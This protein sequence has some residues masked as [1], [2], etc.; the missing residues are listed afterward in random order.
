MLTIYS[1]NKAP[2]SRFGAKCPTSSHRCPELLPNFLVPIDGHVSIP[3]AAL[4]RGL[5]DLH[6]LFK[7]SLIF[8]LTTG[9]G[10]SIYIL[11]CKG[12]LGGFHIQTQE[13]SVFY[14]EGLTRPQ[15][16]PAQIGLEKKG[17]KV[18]LSFGHSYCPWL[19]Q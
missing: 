14:S 1:L 8:V 9:S 16:T 15:K 19:R 13:R 10:S 17:L 4:G 2:H 18:I 5:R 6:M 11:C 3:R 12:Y 7:K